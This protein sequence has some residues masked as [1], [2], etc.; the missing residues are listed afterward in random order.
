M[1][2]R[3]DHK[4]TVICCHG[5]NYKLWAYNTCK[6]E[7]PEQLSFDMDQL[8]STYPKQNKRSHHGQCTTNLSIEDESLYA[9]FKNTYT[10]H[11]Y[12]CIQC[13]VQYSTV[14]LHYTVQCCIL[15]YVYVYSTVFRVLSWGGG[16]EGSTPNS[17]PKNFEIKW[18][19]H[20][21]SLTVKFKTIKVKNCLLR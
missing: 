3:T 12:S 1:T 13:I 17:S 4:Q 15:D 8:F 9:S 20:C 21:R 16:G 6:R 14:L 2:F 18:N 5:S 11:V 19:K 10:L 7:L